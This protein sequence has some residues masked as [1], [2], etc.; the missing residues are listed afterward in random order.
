[1]GLTVQEFL[2]LVV[3]LMNDL[4]LMPIVSGLMVIFG[5]GVGIKI[6]SRI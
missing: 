3:A 4:G 1:M 2:G 6:L 5:V